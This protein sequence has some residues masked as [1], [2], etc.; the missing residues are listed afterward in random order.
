MAVTA[1]IH[2]ALDLR[3]LQLPA[4]LP[5]ERIEVKDYVEVDG[6][7]AVRIRVVIA[8]STDLNHIFG[9]DVG[10]L[11]SAIRESLRQHGIPLYPYI[12]IIKPSELK[13]DESEEE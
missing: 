6:E 8:E 1:E 13:D 12:Y 11:K 5:V 10:E 9:R 7:P 4:S 3:K 2:D